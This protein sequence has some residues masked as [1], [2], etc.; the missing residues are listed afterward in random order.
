M[1]YL[2]LFLFIVLLGCSTDDTA[3]NTPEDTE[4][5]DDEIDSPDDGGTADSLYFPPIGSDTWE[6]ITA[7]ELGWNATAIEP[8]DTFLEENGTKAFILLKNGKIVLE[9]YYQDTD[10]STAH[11]WNSAAKTLTAATIGIAEQEGFLSIQD[12]TQDYLGLG[13]TSMTPEQESQITIRNQL[14]MTTGGDYTVPD[15]NCTDP[16][17]LLYLNPAGSHWY[18]HNAYYTLLQDVVTAA[19]PEDF[20]SYFDT[21]IKEPTGITGLWVPFEYYKLYYSTARS[22]AR[23]GLLN[24]NNGNWNGNQ[25]ID[26]DYFEAMTTPSQDINKA[27]GYLWWL[28][29]QESFRLPTVNATFQGSLISTAPDDLIA[30]L[31]KDDQKLYVVPSKGL[32]VIRLGDAS[33]A[34]L[35]GPSGFDTEL[36]EKISAFIN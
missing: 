12:A 2:Y 7:E 8:L 31:G 27:Y 22:M 6:T 24:L 32:V 4:I 17:C 18:Y 23:F 26:T 35:L 33:D 1:K 16:E 10:A 36:W 13:W 25:V 29:G 28:N 3:I 9:N 19:V 14:T 11:R 5:P 15:I 34:S 20:N 30:G 21:K